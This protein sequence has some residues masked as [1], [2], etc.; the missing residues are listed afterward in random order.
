MELIFYKFCGAIASD[1]EIRIA[2][3]NREESDSAIR[4]TNPE[5]DSQFLKN[6]I[7]LNRTPFFS[8][9]VGFL[10]AILFDTLS[11][12]KSQPNH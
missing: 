10:K 5:L 9:G 11:S 12:A 1:G 4:I 6:R 3:M 8:S 7:L 2:E